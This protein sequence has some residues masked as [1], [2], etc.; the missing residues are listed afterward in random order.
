[1]NC[2]GN[3]ALLVSI[4]G[5]VRKFITTISVSWLLRT[6]PKASDIPDSIKHR[7]I[8]IRIMATMPS[9]P[10]IKLAPKTRAATIINVA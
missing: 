8:A 2:T 6:A 10:V 9:G 3:N 7:T 5:M 1:M 4:S